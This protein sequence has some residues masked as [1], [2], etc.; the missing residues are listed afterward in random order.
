VLKK[1]LCF[2]GMVRDFIAVMAKTVHLGGTV[3]LYYVSV[4]VCFYPLTLNDL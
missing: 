2:D 4:A 3:M 1:F